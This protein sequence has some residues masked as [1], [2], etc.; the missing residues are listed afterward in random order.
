M[1]KKIDRLV[2]KV[3]RNRLQSGSTGPGLVVWFIGGVGGGGCV[4]VFMCMC[5]FQIFKFIF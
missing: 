4:R 2:K 3:G 1:L 5:G